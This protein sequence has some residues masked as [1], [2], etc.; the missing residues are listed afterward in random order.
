MMFNV[1]DGF[2][3]VIGNPPYVRADEPSDWNRAQ[4]QAIMEST[5]YETLW[6]KWDMFVPFIERTY[7][8]LKPNGVTTLI[9]SDAFC[10]AKYAQKPQNWF[11]KNARILRL[12]FFSDLKIFDAAVHNLIYLFQNA[13]GTQ[14]KPERLLHKGEFGNIE[15][16]PTDQQDKLTYRAFFPDNK[17]VKTFDIATVTLD[18]IC[19]ISVGMV[20]HA[21]EKVAQGAFELENL[22]SDIKDKEH[23]K[24]FVEGK[25]LARWLP[26][27]NKWLEWG[28]DR[29]P[30][31]FR[32]P[33]FPELYAHVEKIFIHRTSGDNI[34]CCLDT[35]TTFCNHTIF[36]CVPWIGLTGVRNRSIEK[37]ARYRNEKTPR[38]D[39]P[40]REDLEAVSGR[41]AVKYL[42]AVMNSTVAR[43][44]LRAN[45]RSNTDLYPDDWK[46]LPIPEASPEKQAEIVGLVDQILDAKRKATNADVGDSESQVD[47]M[48]TTLYGLTPEEVAIIEGSTVNA[49]HRTVKK[50]SPS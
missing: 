3:I 1:K 5:T 12:D 13:D 24:P 36:V 21:D 44:F 46:K 33:T 15:R 25:H 47:R 50:I 18:A 6:E 38:P 20:V 37:S 16:L 30:R 17:Q 14:H 29:A 34:R 48:V 32:R 35:Q 40:W 19:Y 4:R 28:T 26:E 43:D 9:V 22:V 41:F 31:L 11:L 2:D 45:R 42:L 10:H 7:K 23:P 27:T 49:G 39:L 8:L